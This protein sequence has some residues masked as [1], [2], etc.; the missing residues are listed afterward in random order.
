MENLFNMNNPVWSF[1]GKLFY[2][3][4]LNLL[5]IICCIPI[6]TIGPSTAAMY[7]VFLKVVRD[8]EGYIARSFFKSFKENLKQGIV[9]TLILLLMLCIGG[10][11]IYFY[12]HNTESV[13]QIFKLL[14]LAVSLFYFIEVLYIFPV[15][16]RFSN[17]TKNL[18]KNALLIGIRDLPKTILIVLIHVAVFVLI[19]S[20]PP[21]IIFGMALAAFL[22][23]YLFVKIFDR[24]IPKEDEER[25]RYTDEEWEEIQ[26]AGEK[27]ESVVY[28]VDDMSGSVTTDQIL[29]QR[30]NDFQSENGKSKDEKKDSDLDGEPKL[31]EDEMM[32]L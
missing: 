13:Y 21:A 17:T 24:Y 6:V 28:S 1:M 27:V 31:T 25:N 2:V 23:S 14:F 22:S 12:N 20:F 3:I 5:W 18:M 29:Q 16:A 32:L 19:W 26:K 9:I 15:L 10:L 30:Q 11:D 4:E 8:E 7:Y